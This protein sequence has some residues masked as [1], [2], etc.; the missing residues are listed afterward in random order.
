M[1]REEAGPDVELLDYCF[2]SIIVFSEFHGCT[3][4]SGQLK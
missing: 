2:G 1:G 4:L 3:A